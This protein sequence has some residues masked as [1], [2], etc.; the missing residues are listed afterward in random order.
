[1]ATRV[2]SF[3]WRRAGPDETPNAISHVAFDRGPLDIRRIAEAGWAPAWTMDRA[4]ADYL[5]WTD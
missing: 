5:A 1:L 4:A 3:A 2:P